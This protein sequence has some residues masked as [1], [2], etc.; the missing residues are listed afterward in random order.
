MKT[1][2]LIRV[3]LGLALFAGPGI[4][5]ETAASRLEKGVELMQEEA[6]VRDAI[7]QF[8]GV[9]RG[10]R[11]SRKLAA[12]ARFHLAKCHLALGEEEQARAQLAALR[13]GWPAE[14][15][16]VIRAVELMPE[17][18]MF[19]PPTWKDG[20]F[21]VYNIGTPGGQSVGCL[22]STIIASEEDGK[23]TWTGWTF[24]RSDGVMLSTV[25]FLADNYRPL[26][27]RIMSPALGD[28]VL[29]MEADGSWRTN[30]P[31]SGEAVG[32][33]EAV[34]GGWNA[35]PLYDND[36]VL[37]LM[38]LLPTEVGTEVSIP[39]TTA[40]MGGNQLEFKLTARKHGSIE[41][42]AGTFDCVYYESNINQNFWVEREGR[43]RIVRIEAGMAEIDL[44]EA[45]ESWNPSEPARRKAEALG[46][47]LEIPA[48]L[49]WTPVADKPEIYRIGLV[50][51]R[52]RIREGMVEI[53]P[54]SNFNEEL[55]DDDEALAEF[56][57]EAIGKKAEDAEI[58]EDSGR[59]VAAGGRTG[60][61]ATMSLTRGKLEGGHTVLVSHADATTAVLRMDHAPG[62][63][64]EAAALLEQIFASL[65]G[66]K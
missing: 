63:E 25:E 18:S 26:R 32:Q 13:E 3:C 22:Y 64:K 55:R 33:G 47:S 37:H 11:Q 8:E 35:S 43:K 39:I 20:E 6:T 15:P 23:K 12:E 60:R 14:N 24:R 31:V 58:V 61:I 36:Q 62:A 7:R 1:R 10:E 16:W 28:V 49:I 2:P 53:Q 50:D 44:V 45:D 57:L 48:G 9:L 30:R 56:L 42:E 27:G 65:D 66:L 54:T 38:R 17:P 34:A 29:R 46:V 52:F 5:E 59:E 51:S 19:C 41:V 21:L 4:A 40:L